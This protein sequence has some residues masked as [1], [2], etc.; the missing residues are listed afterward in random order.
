MDESPQFDFKTLMT[1]QKNKKVATCPECDGPV[2]LKGLPKIGQRLTCRRCGLS[3]VIIYHKPLELERVDGKFT[4]NGHKKTRKKY[5]RIEYNSFHRTTKY[6]KGAP[7]LTT[8]QELIAK[9]PECDTTLQFHKA[10]RIGQLV[11]CF[12][13][14]ETLEVV[15]ID[16]LDFYWANE[17]PWDWDG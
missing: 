7:M 8:S 16:P 17:D 4:G 5:S 6:K 3:L 1:N 9:C 15:S 12:E 2:P 10:L 11:S 14:G 13:C